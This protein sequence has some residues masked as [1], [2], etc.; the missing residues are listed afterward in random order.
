[1]SSSE[2]DKYLT[3][4]NII[5]SITVHRKNVKTKE[6]FTCFYAS[7]N[8]QESNAKVPRLKLNIM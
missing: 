8:V 7:E 5:V 6:R 1:M 4:T 2:T 3:G